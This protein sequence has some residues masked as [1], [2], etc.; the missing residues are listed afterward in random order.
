ME[1]SIL[2][3]SPT[4]LETERKWKNFSFQQPIHDHSTESVVHLLRDWIMH[5][6]SVESEGNKKEGKK[7]KKQKSDPFK[8]FL[9]FLLFPCKIILRLY[10][11]LS[12]YSNSNSI[13]MFT[14]ILGDDINHDDSPGN[15]NKCCVIIKD[16]V[17][18]HQAGNRGKCFHAIA[19][20]VMKEDGINCILQFVIHIWV[21]T[22][23]HKRHKITHQWAYIWLQK[24]LDEWSMYYYY[25]AALCK[26]VD[27][28]AKS[29]RKT[30]QFINPCVRFNISELEME[31]KHST[32]VHTVYIIRRI[33]L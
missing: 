9:L 17:I 19:F 25:Y 33:V 29:K 32:R 8:D 16:Y 10:L 7:K 3:L 22:H 6:T 20:N 2:S 5:W 11:S 31:G 26:W 24:L 30:M 13:L 18:I 12:S 23:T 27:R 21:Q 4:V 15:Y 14:I 28:S 1:P